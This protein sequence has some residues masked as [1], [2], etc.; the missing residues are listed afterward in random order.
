MRLADFYGCRPNPLAVA[1]VL[2]VGG[3]S[4]ELRPL[5]LGQ[6]LELWDAV[7]P[8][9]PQWI[10]Y[11][12]KV[13]E[14]GERPEDGDATEWDAA[15]R[16]LDTSW[17]PFVYGRA[18]SV[19][20]ADKGEAWLHEMFDAASGEDLAELYAWYVDRHDWRRILARVFGIVVDDEGRATQQETDH[21][22]I[23]M[24]GI[25]RNGGRRIEDLLSMRVE[26]YLSFVEIMEEYIKR[27]KAS[28]NQVE[29]GLVG[30]GVPGVSIS[31]GSPKPKIRFPP[32][33]PLHEP[34]T[35]N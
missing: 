9:M 12:I 17:L 22:L 23:V 30:L 15:F 1:D 20:F 33:H 35:E 16:G 4:V 25:E 27:A 6:T 18:G 24:Y 2:V 32:G 26:A 8:W 13:S 5:T 11:L 10:E 19:L 28:D 34:E 14:L 29:P 3:R 21:P 7:L 31:H